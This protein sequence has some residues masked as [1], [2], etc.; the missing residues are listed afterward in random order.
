MVPYAELHVHSNF[1][2]LD[3]ASSPED[4]LEEAVR[5]GL[6]AIALTDHD[7]FYGVARLAETAATY[8]M[9]TVF[10]AELSL[11]LTSPQNGVAD[12][13][14]SHLLVLAE[15][16]EGYHR[17]AGAI[18][19]AHLAGAEKGRPSYDLEDVA[20]RGR[21]QWLILTGCRKGLVRQALRPPGARL[22]DV[23]AAAKELDRLVALF[24]RDRV[25]VE[26]IDHGYPTA[27]TEN[28]ALAALARDAGLATVA[29]GNVHYA[30]PRWAKLAA[31]LAAVRARW[32]LDEMD[33][34]LPAGP[35]AFL[36]S[37]EEM[38]H[39]FRHGPRRTATSTWCCPAERAA[40]V[41][42]VRSAAG[43]TPRRADARTALRPF[44][45]CV[46]AQS[47]RSESCLE[48]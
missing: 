20:E 35:S 16:Q 10:G 7:G 38:A 22:V 40:L 39:R 15:G 24:G 11:D 21:D 13:E 19:E 1:S 9:Q 14:G 31:A 42:P 37:G 18:T 23:G 36:R 34:W 4:L 3:G 30:A 41:C 2:F 28:D 45:R 25:V 29:T 44:A 6:H 46:P 26:L 8:D 17:L 12:P 27:S 5:L 43:R 32:S 47:R 33:G 48:A